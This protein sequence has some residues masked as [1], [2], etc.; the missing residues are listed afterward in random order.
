[1]MPE[2]IAKVGR[3]ENAHCQ[4]FSP[5]L[6][7]LMIAYA[8]TQQQ[9]SGRCARGSVIAREPDLVVRAFRPDAA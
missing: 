8:K 9:S 7:L 4:V 6:R 5:V 1:M 2:G 3:F